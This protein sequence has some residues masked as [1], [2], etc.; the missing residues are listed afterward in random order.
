[1]STSTPA[2]RITI[3]EGD[4]IADLA[5]AIRITPPGTT[6]VVPDTEIRDIGI[7]AANRMRRGDLIFEAAG[8]VAADALGQ[9]A[10]ERT[11]TP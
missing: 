6:I 11:G 2:N 3:A 4:W 7:R 9:P 1:M 5:R 10:D 8:R